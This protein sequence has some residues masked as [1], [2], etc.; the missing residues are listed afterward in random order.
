MPLSVENAICQVSYETILDPD[1]S[2]SG[3]LKGDL[4]LPHAL[5]VHPTYSHDFL[6]DSFPTAEVIVETMSYH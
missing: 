1:M 5:V 4:V 3:T 2:S 6:D